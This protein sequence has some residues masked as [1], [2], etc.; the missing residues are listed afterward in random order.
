M[1]CYECE[2]TRRDVVVDGFMIMQN[3]DGREGCSGK[4]MDNGFGKYCAERER[5]RI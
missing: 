5:L 3:N 4:E 2:A 1:L